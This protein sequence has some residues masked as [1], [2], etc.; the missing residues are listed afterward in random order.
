MPSIKLG[1]PGSH[2][3]SKIHF[4]FHAFTACWHRMD[5]PFIVPGHDELGHPREVSYTPSMRCC[6]C[7]RG[8]K[9]HGYG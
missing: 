4:L 9:V 3:P 8:S 7:R 2:A 1:P 5:E 6:I